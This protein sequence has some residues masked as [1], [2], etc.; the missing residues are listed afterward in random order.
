LPKPAQAGDQA[1]AVALRSA[2]TW[3]QK[4]KSASRTGDTSCFSRRHIHAV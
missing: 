2:R 3:E 4:A 1:E